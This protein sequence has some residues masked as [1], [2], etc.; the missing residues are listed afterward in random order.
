[1]SQNFLETHEF[2]GR[3]VKVELDL[4]NY[5]KKVYLKGETGIDTSMLLSKTN[6]ASMRTKIDNLDVDKLKT[7]PVDLRKLCNV[8]DNNV[9]KKLYMIN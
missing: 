1:M 8:I 6:L 5:A 3:N 2:S 4:S 9:A 7:V